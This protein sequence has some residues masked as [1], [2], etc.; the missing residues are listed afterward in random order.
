MAAATSAFGI[1]VVLAGGIFAGPSVA[2]AAPPGNCD[3]TIDYGVW[4]SRLD[5]EYIGGTWVNCGRTWDHVRIRVS[6]ASDSNCVWVGPNTSKHISYNPLWF[7]EGRN[8]ARS[9]TRC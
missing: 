4:D 3:T 9:W 2:L 1:A 8:H 7:W 5:A 6:N